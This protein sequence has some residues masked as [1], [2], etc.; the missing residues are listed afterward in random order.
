[1]SSV[2]GAGFNFDDW[3]CWLGGSLTAFAFPSVAFHCFFAF[4]EVLGDCFDGEAGPRCIMVILYCF[5]PRGLG[6]E[7]CRCMQIMHRLRL[8]FEL[9]DVVDSLDGRWTIG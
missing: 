4:G 8:H 5:Y 6:G 9:V 1:M 7:T 2:N 3:F